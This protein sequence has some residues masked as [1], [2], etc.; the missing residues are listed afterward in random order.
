MKQT[1]TVGIAILTCLMIVGCNTESE[2]LAFLAEQTMKSQN[3]VNNTVSRTTQSLA[4]L[5]RDVQ[6]ERRLIEQDRQSIQRQFE[7]LQN[8]RKDL[9]RERRS[10]LAWSEAF[11]FLAIIVAASLPLLLCAF[12]IWVATRGSAVQDEVNAI[13]L[14]EMASPSPRLIAGSDLAAAKQKPKRL[15]SPKPEDTTSNQGRN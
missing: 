3:G 14:Q 13:L 10:E 12:L 15:E 9:N 11:Q 5:N 8:E 1:W 2:R 6:N 7:Q 4:N